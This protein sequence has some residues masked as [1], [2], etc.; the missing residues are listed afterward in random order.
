[1]RNGGGAS[2]SP[3]VDGEVAEDIV[4]SLC[5]HRGLSRFCGGWMS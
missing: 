1:M 4:Q 5:D 2:E 3:A